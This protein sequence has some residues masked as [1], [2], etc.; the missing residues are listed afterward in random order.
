MN[1][2]KVITLLAAVFSLAVLVFGMS[3]CGGEKKNISVT[4]NFEEGKSEAF[5][6]VTK[7][8]TLTEALE[9][10]KI[11]VFEKSGDDVRIKSVKGVEADEK[12][13]EKWVL[14]KGGELFDAAIDI[15]IADGDVFELTFIEGID[16]KNIAEFFEKYVESDSRPVAVMIDNDNSDARPQAGL[17]D[18]FLAYEMFVEGGAT[19]YMALFKNDTTEKIGPVRSSRH[20][21]LDY[22]MENDA[23]YGHFGWSPL[24]AKDI[25]ALG[26]NNINGLFDASTYYRDYSVTSDWHT[27][28]TKMES[29]LK[30]AEAKGYSQTTSKGNVFEYN[31]A[32]KDLENGK[33]AEKVTLKYSGFYNTGY[34]YDAETKLY[35]K[36]LGSSDYATQSGR[37]VTVK[38]VIVQYVNNYNLGDGSARQQ[39]DTVGSGEGFYITNGKCVE[40]NWSKASR[41]A[42]TVYTDKSGKEIKL[43]PGK[44][45][46]NIINKSLGAVIE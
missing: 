46:V 34:K 23:I 4:V 41:N 5:D 42:K 28:Y 29:L 25:P 6:V 32:D 16:E 24:A 13:S 45:F 10:E 7:A 12:K 1:S 38:N 11:A 27:A 3:G 14:S 19:R 44:T 17:E 37:P 40:I 36:Q 8:E 33:A 18:A 26:I 22:V 15:V 43:N 9:K 30:T 35:T 20:Y 31:R 21:F 39:L 2:K